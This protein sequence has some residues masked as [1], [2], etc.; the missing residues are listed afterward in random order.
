[1]TSFRRDPDVPLSLVISADVGGELLHVGDEAMLQANIDRV[2]ELACDSRIALC[3]DDS[4]ALRQR[5]DV[6]T[7]PLPDANGRCSPELEVALAQADALW[8]SGG[9]NLCSTWPR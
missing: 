4:H 8:V 1:M 3:A 7:V 5:L 6:D 2:R 9:G